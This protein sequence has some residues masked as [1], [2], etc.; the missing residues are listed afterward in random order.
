MSLSN[1][2][3]VAY[4]APAVIGSTLSLSLQTFAAPFWASEMGFGA[5]LVG[6]IF[7]AVR[8]FDLIFDPLFGFVSDR[9]Q[10]RWGRRRHWFVITTPVLMFAI[11]FFYNPPPGAGPVYLTALLTLLYVG[12]SITTITHMSLG[13][14]LSTD[15]RKRNR[16]K[17]FLRG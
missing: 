4:A 13:M 8:I 3:L 1:S 11:Y 14:E 17:G 5:A 2:A 6:V 10:T 9:F 15:F 7:G 12:W 16:I